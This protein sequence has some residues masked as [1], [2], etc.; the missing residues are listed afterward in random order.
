MQQKCVGWLRRRWD[1]PETT[2]IVETIQ[3]FLRNTFCFSNTSR[4]VSGGSDRVN[5]RRFDSGKLS[6]K[7]E[8][9]IF[10]TTLVDVTLVQSSPWPWMFGSDQRTSGAC[11]SRSG[12]PG[13]NILLWTIRRKSQKSGFVEATTYVGTSIPACEAVSQNRLF[14]RFTVFSLLNVRGKLFIQSI[15]VRSI[16]VLT[17]INGIPKNYFKARTRTYV[18][19]EPVVRDTGLNTY[20]LIMRFC[21]CVQ[22]LMLLERPQ[23]G[24]NFKMFFFALFWLPQTKYATDITRFIADLNIYWAY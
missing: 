2:L 21:V 5:K 1:S 23:D 13:N 8:Q 17:N 19:D 16:F 12:H 22:N 18:H 9:V 3:I 14:I 10:R 11:W 20:C 15:R 24:I 6:P 4:R 7:S